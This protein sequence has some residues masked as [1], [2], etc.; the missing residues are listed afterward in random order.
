MIVA[1]PD[2]RVQLS[3][4]ARSTSSGSA[5]PRCPVSPGSWPARHRRQRQRRQGLAAAESPAALGVTATSVTPPNTSTVR[6]PSSCR[7]RSAPTTPRSSGAHELGLRVWPRCRG[8]PVGP[9]RP[10]RGGRH[11]HAWQDDDDLDARDRP[12]AP[13]APTRRTRSARPCNAVRAQR[14]CRLGCR[15]SSSR[16]TRATGRSWPTRRQALSS[17]T[18]TSTTSTPSAPPRRTPTSLTHSSTGSSRGLPRLLCRRPGAARLADVARAQHGLTVRHGRP[19][20][21]ARPAGRAT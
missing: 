19:R 11:R 18:S 20:A 4:W 14:R 17:P 12:A 9:A 7:P 13:A 21:T 10:T 8:R 5:A 3:S 2:D 1:L 15:S 6:T 16:E